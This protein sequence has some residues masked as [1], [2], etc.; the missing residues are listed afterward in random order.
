MD[1]LLGAARLDNPGTTEDDWTTF[2]VY[3]DDPMQ[4][5]GSR[6]RE[7]YYVVQGDIAALNAIHP[8]SAAAAPEAAPAAAEPAATTTPAPATATP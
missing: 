3:N 8:A 2:E 1:A 5:G 4:A 7:I 6:N